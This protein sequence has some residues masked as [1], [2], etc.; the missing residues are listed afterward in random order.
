MS[1]WFD[2]NVAR[3]RIRRENDFHNVELNLVRQPLFVS[4]WGYAP[5]IHGFKRGVNAG[6][7]AGFRFL[8]FDE[9]FQFASDR[10]NEVFGDNAFDEM[11]FDIDVENNLIGAQVGGHLE[12]GL[13]GCLNF[14]SELKMGVYGN[15][16]THT[17]RIGGANGVATVGAGPNAGRPYDV[18]F[19]KNDVAFIG[20]LKLGLA[21]HFYKRWVLTGGYRAV[22]LTGVAL[23]TNQIPRDLRGIDDVINVDSN[24][25]LIL[26]GSYAGI[27]YSW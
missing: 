12:Y 4:G 22:A 17:S 18:D 8:K 24:G 7:L 3:H 15:H 5:A 21:Y 2:N 13:T 6:W 19:S 9:H 14:T 1:V 11:F 23:A 20:E 16:I 27:E 25:S 26:H 10:A